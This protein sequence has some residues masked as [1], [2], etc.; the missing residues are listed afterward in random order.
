VKIKAA[1]HGRSQFI[2]YVGA[3]LFVS[4]PSI[5]LMT[6]AAYGLVLLP[7]ET[8]AGSGISLNPQLIR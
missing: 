7:I 3:D 6:S 4:T 8:L 2:Y 1:K 5:R